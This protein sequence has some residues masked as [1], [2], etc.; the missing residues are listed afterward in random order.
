MLKKIK[1]AHYT[2]RYIAEVL[3]GTVSAVGE[4]FEDAVNKLKNKLDNINTHIESQTCELD[5]N[6]KKDLADFL[7]NTDIEMRIRHKLK[8]QHFFTQ[9]DF[10]KIGIR[11]IKNHTND[12]QDVLKG[13]GNSFK[14]D[15]IS[16]TNGHTEFYAIYDME[17]FDTYSKQLRLADELRRLAF[18]I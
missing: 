10:S 4:T 9:K 8:H 12:I 15:W 11:E 17:H 14:L 1:K 3:N 5:D 16:V 6:D 18:G 2:A 7:R 13:L